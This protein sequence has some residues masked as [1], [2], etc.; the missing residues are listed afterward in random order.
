MAALAA[1]LPK[2]EIA[3]VEMTNTFR[4]EQRLGPVKVDPRLSAAARTYA[5]F[6][7][8][9]S[10]FSHTADGRQHAD[11]AKS[12]GYRFCMLS[13]NLSYN[14]DERGFETSQLARN[15]LEGWKKSPGHRRNLVAPEVTEI[16]VGVAKAKDSQKYYSVQMFGR[17]DSARYTFKIQNGLP[18]TV[19]YA[20]AGQRHT[21]AP[22]EVVTH[23]PCAPAPVAFERAGPPLIGHA[24][25]GTYQTR[26]GDLFT[27]K[28]S[29]AGGVIID[30]T[31]KA[32]EPVRAG[33][34]R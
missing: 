4:A 18:Q 2:V 10:M 34:T 16:G 15:A 17:P 23:Y 14:F 25:K 31:S 5:E 33:M 12:A 32:S 11:R 1:D 30:L 28:P 29:P 13:E 9:S 26:D 21:V 24:L 19:T 7:A 27:L 6:L 20:F 3:I 22:R 8:A